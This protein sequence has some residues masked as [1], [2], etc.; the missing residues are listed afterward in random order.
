MNEGPLTQKILEYAALL[1]ADFS[2]VADLALAY[3]AI[4]EQGG[5]VVAGYS[6]AV[7][8]GI[9]L[10]DTI[11]DQ[12]PRRAERAVAVS[13]RHHAYDV[14]N[15]RL[16]EMASRMASYLYSQGYA[17]LP[18]PASKRV[19]DERI[20][21][22]FSHKMAAHLAGLGWIGKSCLLIT[23]QA[24][25]RVRWITV[26]TDA[27]LQATGEPMAER[28]GEC[29]AC[30]KICPVEAFSDRAFDPQEPREARFDA[31]KCDLYMQELEK[32]GPPVCGMCLYVCPYGR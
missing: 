1:E 19:D 2:G 8:L 10:M 25:P 13:Y 11:V 32:K 18:V 20:C 16:D 27:P 30:V 14:V 12:L 31:R 5:P 4:L 24:G 3:Q 6:K 15:A 23:P 22:F 29:S 28:C 7:S 17:A 26:L 9:T 21:S